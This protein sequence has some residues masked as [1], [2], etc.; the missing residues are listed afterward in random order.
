MK[1]DTMTAQTTHQIAGDF[2]STLHT[3]RIQCNNGFLTPAAY[4]TLRRQL[5]CAIDKLD[6]MDE[7]YIES[8]RLKTSTSN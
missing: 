2:A 5:Y 8:R 3:L 7:V 4:K 6:I 1:E